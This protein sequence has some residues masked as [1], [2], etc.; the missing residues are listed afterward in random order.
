MNPGS[1]RWSSTSTTHPPI[2]GFLM[3]CLAS[4]IYRIRRVAHNIEVRLGLAKPTAL[5]INARY[6]REL[7]RLMKAVLHPNATCIDIGAN[8]GA[9]LEKMF[10]FA[11]HG[12]HFAIEP[13]P[14][15]ATALNQKFTSARV[16]QCACSDSNGQAHF[17]VARNRSALSG[18]RRTHNVGDSAMDILHVDVRTLDSMIPADETIALIKI[19]AEG[20]EI[21]IMRG[22]RETITRCR[23]YVVFEAGSNTTGVYN[24]NADDVY[25]CVTRELGMQLSTMS[26]FFRGEP[27]FSREEFRRASNIDGEPFLEGC[28][29]FDFFFLACDQCSSGAP[30]ASA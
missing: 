29:D 8:T 21:P 24:I 19:D 15:L 7:T 6:D 26:R 22:A 1:S 13:V 4:A 14:A 27:A 3:R 11:P 20:N 18:L 10:R 17:H 12:R 28:P 30:R 2:I 9:I 5:E 23:P 25:D 16:L